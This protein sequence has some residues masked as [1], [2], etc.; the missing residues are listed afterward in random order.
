MS[1]LFDQM[2]ARGFRPPSYAPALRKYCK[3]TRVTDITFLSFLRPPTSTLPSLPA[4]ILDTRNSRSDIRRTSRPSRDSRLKLSHRLRLGCSTVTT[5]INEPLAADAAD[6]ISLIQTSHRGSGPGTTCIQTSKPAGP[7]FTPLRSFITLLYLGTI[8]RSRR[9]ICFSAFG[10]QRS[11][12]S[13]RRGSERERK[14]GGDLPG[15]CVRGCHRETA[16]DLRF[17]MNGRL[18]RTRRT[19]FSGHRRIKGRDRGGTD[20]PFGPWID[21]VSKRRV[22]VL[23][24]TVCA[25]RLILR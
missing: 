23:S 15:H 13:V 25:L 11:G 5:L 24:V 2:R 22:G 20:C 8:H 4:G 19:A 1:L 18:L 16:A 3:A 7:L 12:G 14:K 10:V 17:G 21:Q 6:A 9:S